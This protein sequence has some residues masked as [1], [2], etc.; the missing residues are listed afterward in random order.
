M[1]YPPVLVYETS[2]LKD[3]LVASLVVISAAVLDRRRYIAAIPLVLLMI[4]VRANAVLFPV[5]LLGYLRRAHLRYVLVL[6]GALV[7]AALLMLSQGYFAAMAD[8][9]HL[10]PATIL[11]FVAKYLL[12][13]LPT[14]ILDYGTEAVWIFPVVYAV[15]RRGSSLAFSRR[16]STAVYVRTGAGSACC[17]WCVSLRICHTSTN[18]TS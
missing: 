14:N 7:G 16:A 17:W 11:F 12:G 9:I 2:F 3:D 10:P 8:I 6:S 1:L 13:P 4:A 15:L 18:S 5:I